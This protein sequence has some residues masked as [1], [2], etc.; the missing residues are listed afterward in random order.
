MPRKGRRN[1][2]DLER[3]TAK[4]FVAA[5]RQHPAMKS[6]INNL[7]H[8]ELRLVRTHG[9]VGFARTVALVMV[10]AN[11]HRIGLTLKRQEEW[12]RRRHPA[13]GRAA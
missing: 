8:R 6:A 5:R 13:H 2:E 10:A 3:E 1:Q 4:A 11:M 7:N 9:A 12:R